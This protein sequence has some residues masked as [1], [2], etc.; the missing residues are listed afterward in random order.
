[1]SDPCAGGLGNPPVPDRLQSRQDVRGSECRLA[2]GSKTPFRPGRSCPDLWPGL[3]GQA[4]GSRLH[5]E[6]GQV[7]S[8]LGIPP[9]P[10]I[11]P[12]K[13]RRDLFLFQARMVA[14]VGAVRSEYHGCPVSSGDLLSASE[15]GILETVALSSGRFP[16]P[17]RRSCPTKMSRT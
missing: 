7:Y 15:R 2:R 3:Q 10:Q 1:M 4:R 9:H 11:Q 12:E 14:Q 16:C 6:S 17:C 13:R 8:G 5:R